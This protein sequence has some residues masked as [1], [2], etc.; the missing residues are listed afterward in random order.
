MSVSPR[1]DGVELCV[2]DT[3]VGISP[4]VLPHI[5]DLF[6]QG[7]SSTTRRYEG[8]GLGLYIVQ[9]MMELLQGTVTVESTESQGSTFRVWVPQRLQPPDTVQL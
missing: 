9:R 5:F 6:H 3:G 2:T 7:D 8:V 1:D 4:E